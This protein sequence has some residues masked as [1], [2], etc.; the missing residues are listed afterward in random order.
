MKI[1]D[2][3]KLVLERSNDFVKDGMVG[4]VLK[5]AEEIGKNVYG[6]YINR[7]MMGVKTINGPYE[8]VVTLD[9][10]K[11]LNSV[12]KEIGDDKVVLSNF[13]HLT[14]HAAYNLSMPRLIKGEK[15]TLGVID[16]D[17]KSIYIKPYSIDKIKQRPTDIVQMYVPASGAYNSGEDTTDENSYY[18]RCDSVNKTIKI[19]MSNKNGEISKYD[20]L[21]DGNE[22]FCSLTDGLR[23]VSIN[24]P[25]DEIFMTNEAGTI[26]SLKEDMIDMRC[27]KFY[28]KATDLINVEC[29]TTELKLDNITQTTEDYSADIKSITMTGDTI[30][31]AFS[32]I[33]VE[34]DKY[35]GTISSTVFDGKMGVTEDFIVEKV[36]GFGG[37]AGKSVKPSDPQ[38]KSDGTT[39]FAGAPSAALAKAQSVMNVLTAMAGVIDTKMPPAPGVAS[40][41]VQSLGM[42]VPSKKAKG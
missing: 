30:E 4:V 42:M 41:L 36:I 21:I 40:A 38:I 8:E 12:N 35:T 31:K 25:S 22:G 14:Y 17:I 24:T 29:P 39:K 9:E 3:R 2:Y 10:N 37:T 18:V 7:L 33:S 34:A 28:L 13:V 27:A 6:I 32:T 20:I 11:C 5:T 19:H 15:V 23:T 1:T 26:V 16:Q